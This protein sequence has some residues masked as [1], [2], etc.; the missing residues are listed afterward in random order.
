MCFFLSVQ[1]L[2]SGYYV[3]QIKG[4][5][6]L[7]WLY[8]Q[9][10][11][12]TVAEAIFCST[13]AIT[14]GTKALV[15]WKRTIRTVLLLYSCVSLP[16]CPFLHSS[17]R[18]R[19]THRSTGSRFSTYLRCFSPHLSRRVQNYGHAICLMHD[20]IH[21]GLPPKTQTAHGSE[22][23]VVARACVSPFKRVHRE[24]FML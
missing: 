4:L 1:S 7:S 12:I 21:Q 9:T 14:T 10:T 22:Q 6:R 16:S 3:A 20:L 2:M 5:V 23:R 13:F 19:V 8:L 24:Q 15:L 11:E 17:W 18:T